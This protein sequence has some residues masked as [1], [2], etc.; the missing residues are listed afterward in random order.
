MF[1]ITFE[2]KLFIFETYFFPFFE[3]F[4]CLDGRAK[5]TCPATSCGP[6]ILIRNADFKIRVEIC[7]FCLVLWWKLLK[8]GCRKFGKTKKN[9]DCLQ[10]A[11]AGLCIVSLWT[12]F[13]QKC[14]LNR[15]CYFVNFWKKNAFFINFAAIFRLYD[16]DWIRKY[17][18]FKYSFFSKTQ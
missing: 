16:E 10:W 14:L 2:A 7:L 17:C 11:T 1:L 4:I 3:I 6:C 5:K 15:V 8:I 13:F 9:T 12:H 18:I